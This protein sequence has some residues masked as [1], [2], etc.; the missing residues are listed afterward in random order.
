MWQGIATHA[1]PGTRLDDWDGMARMKAQRLML[2]DTARLLRKAIAM[3]LAFA[4]LV[5]PG[6]LAKATVPAGHDGGFSHLTS[7]LVA[8]PTPGNE[9]CHHCDDTMDCPCCVGSVCLIQASLPVCASVVRF[10]GTETA[11][12]GTANQQLLSGIG[13]IPDLPPPRV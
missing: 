3:V 13:G 12:F 5:L 10:A 6:F 8:G 11:Q 1:T 7:V 2:I 4:L 9:P